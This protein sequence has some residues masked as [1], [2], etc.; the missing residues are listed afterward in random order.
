MLRTVL[1]LNQCYV[2]AGNCELLANFVGAHAPPVSG[3]PSAKWTSA[4]FW[5]PSS[6]RDRASS[7]WALPTPPSPTPNPQWAQRPSISLL[8]LPGPGRRRQRRALGICF[9]CGSAVT[10]SGGG[11][12]CP[13]GLPAASAWVMLSRKH[14]GIFII[15]GK[16][17][18]QLSC[19]RASGFLPSWLEAAHQGLEGACCHG[20]THRPPLCSPIPLPPLPGGRPLQ[21]EDSSLKIKVFPQLPLGLEEIAASEAAGGHWDQQERDSSWERRILRPDACFPPSSAAA[22]CCAPR[23]DT[24]T[25]CAL[26]RH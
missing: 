14:N 25:G 18:T 11:G 19:C 2:S 8:Q 7:C 24:D 26:T 5:I 13:E 4:P 16:R 10:G 6:C 9:V 21:M 3:V 12:C 15:K 20:D 22:P 23:A 1:T 17:R